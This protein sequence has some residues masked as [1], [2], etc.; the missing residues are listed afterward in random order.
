MLIT[1]F[2]S[3]SLLLF[4]SAAASLVRASDDPRTKILSN[5]DGT[6]YTYCQAPFPNSDTHP[7]P[8]VKGSVL[9]SVQIFIRHGD[10]TPTSALE[11]D[12]DVTWDCDD[13][14][15]YIYT[16]SNNHLDPQNSLKQ[17]FAV[18]RQIIV[19]PRKSP[20]ARYSWKGSCTPGQ[21][22]PLGA[23]QHRTLGGIL[24]DIYVD[25]WKFLPADFDPSTLYVRSTDVWR[26]Q[27]SAES[28]ITGLYGP[29]VAE[30]R[31]PFFQMEVVPSAVEYMTI[32]ADLCPKAKDLEQVIKKKFSYK[33]V[34]NYTR[35]YLSEVRQIMGSDASLQDSVLPRLCHEMEPYCQEGQPDR[36]TTPA[37]GDLISSK[38]ALDTA[39][40]YRDA[41]ESREFLRLGMG[42]LAKDILD[43][44]VTASPL[45][46]Q[47][48][49]YSGHDNT[50]APLLGLLESTDMRWPPYAS[51]LIF[52]L[53]TAPSSERFVRIFQ[54]G[55]LMKT[56]T[57]WCNLE[58]CAM[59]QFTAN[60]EKYI[61]GD[62]LEEC[63]TE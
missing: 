54:N 42:P 17:S 6:R 23:Q 40:L 4:I 50:L 48:K 25:R 34:Q 52:E 44:F 58:W 33:Q 22:T 62:V 3:T 14:G 31:P 10:R 39:A 43:N 29:Q 20:F 45:V 61:P 2:S 13:L 5:A 26:T 21:L 1:I 18:A 59:S 11:A 51:N 19:S 12:A 37:M 28:L 16:S 53:W 49:L 47:F 9:T 60:M 15:S 63:E 41:P 57:N 24:R 32:N 36:C 46:P 56:T 27:Q 35:G 55:N 30:G 38:K 7:E 8:E